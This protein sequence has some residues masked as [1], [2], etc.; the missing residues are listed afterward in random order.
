MK[1]LL[2]TLPYIRVTRHSW[3]GRL[4]DDVLK[5]SHIAVRD[6][7]EL[8]SLQAAAEMVGRG[9]GVSIMPLYEGKWQDDPR[10]KIWIIDRPRIGRAIGLIER[11]AHTRTA[12]TAAL[13][14]CLRDQ[15][16]P[17]TIGLERIEP[18]ENIGFAIAHRVIDG[19]IG[20]ERRFDRLALRPGD[21]GERRA[22]LSPYLG[23]GMCRFA[24]PRA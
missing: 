21:R 9:L 10:L 12:I 11:Q 16:A 7:M 2:A 22:L 5:R 6:A 19:D 4:I 23:I 3:T 18:P 14:D 15:D 1:Q 17:R 8:D 20:S 24:R 13:L